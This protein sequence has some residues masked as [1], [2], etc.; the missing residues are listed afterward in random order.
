MNQMPRLVVVGHGAA[1]LAAAVAAAQAARHRG[2]AVDIALVEKA[3]EDRAGGNTLWSPSYIRLDAPDRLADEFEDDMAKATGGRGDK[4]YFRALAE[5]ATATMAWLQGHGIEFCSPTYYLSAGPKRIQP[6][7]GGRALIGALSRAATR[8]GVTFHYEHA[9]TELVMADDGRIGAVA[10]AGRDGTTTIPAGA[11]VLATGG[12]Q[13]NAAMMREHFGPGGDS[14]KLISPGTGYNTGDGIRMAMAVGARV[15]GDWNGMH[16]EPVDPRAKNAAPVV[17][18]YPYG[19]VADQNGRRFVDEGSGLVHETWEHFSRKIHFETPGGK[20]YAVL[21]SRLLDIP[22]YERAI[23]SEVPPHKADTLADLARLIGVD[24][25][26]IETTVADYNRSASGDPARFDASRCDGLAASGR[27]DPPKSN[28][29]RA[30]AKPPFLAYPIVGAVAYTFGGL[31]T[32]DKAELLGPHGPLPGLYAAG[33]ITG[34]FFGTAPNAVA[35]LRALV[36]GRIA[37]CEAISYFEA[38]D[39]RFGQHAS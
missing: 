13:A 1:G 21:D 27:L 32:N 30:I 35:I 6:V 9:A 20:A 12:F 5:N 10:V 17:L 34:H 2:L 38:R 4:R 31:A 11:V 15:S 19:I 14:L 26:A 16:I 7:G 18:V 36:F 8:L 24:A 39:G 25:A 33:E 37:G 23:R 22:G 28:W 29:A 3:S